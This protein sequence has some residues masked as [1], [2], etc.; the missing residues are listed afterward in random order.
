MMEQM[1]RESLEVYC[2]SL[3][4]G[5]FW[6]KLPPAERAY[7]DFLYTLRNDPDDSDKHKAKLVKDFTMNNA[8]SMYCE[9]PG[10]IGTH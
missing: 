4:N 10:D 6:G 7:K 2:K 8:A 9:I 5:K 1:P 3:Q